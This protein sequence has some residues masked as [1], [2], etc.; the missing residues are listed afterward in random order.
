MLN[1]LLKEI[2]IILSYVKLLGAEKQKCYWNQEKSY[3]LLPYQLR[4]TIVFYIIV[5]TCISLLSWGDLGSESEKLL[6][7]NL[8][9]GRRNLQNIILEEWSATL[10]FSYILHGSSLLINYFSWVTQ[11]L[12]FD[13]FILYQFLIL[14]RVV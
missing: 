13:L 12:F 11:W 1:L 2:V 8:W 3:Q 5:D 9:K 10:S 14:L 4:R 7:R 6:Q